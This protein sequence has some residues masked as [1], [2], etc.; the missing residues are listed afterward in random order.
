MRANFV[1]RT[2]TAG[3]PATLA[4]HLPPPP[5][6]SMLP[7]A[8]TEFSEPQKTTFGGRK[9]RQ[10]R[11]SKV[12]MPHGGTGTG[13]A[14]QSFEYRAPRVLDKF[15]QESPFGKDDRDEDTNGLTDSDSEDEGNQQNKSAPS[16][17]YRLQRKGNYGYL[18]DKFK[19]DNSLARNLY[20]RPRYCPCTAK[21]GEDLP[22]EIYVQSA[23]S[24]CN[25]A[26]SRCNLA[27]S[28]RNPAKSRRNPRHC[29]FGF[30]RTG[31]Q[32]CLC[33]L[34]RGGV[35]RCP[36][37]PTLIRAPALFGGAGGWSV[38]PLALP[39]FFRTEPL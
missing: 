20:G 34:L 19:P 5:V 6:A 3:R 35:G 16:D 22:T 21:Q 27:K 39:P 12:H 36:G 30:C 10:S 17:E 1:F 2:W 7:A 14:T 23:K 29:L 38:R 37:V 33:G 24:R 8:T 28:R 18:S 4:R 25:L 31:R 11:A 32:L 15:P 13:V 26:K 9:L